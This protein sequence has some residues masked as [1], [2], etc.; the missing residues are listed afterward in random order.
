MSEILSAPTPQRGY[1]VAYADTIK[2]YELD[3]VPAVFWRKLE[4]VYPDKE[5]LT[6]VYVQEAGREI[7]DVM[8]QLQVAAGKGWFRLFVTA[9]DGRREEAPGLRGRAQVQS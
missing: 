4:L 5:Q 2:G 7:R 9:A 3:K 1:P 8:W 6:L